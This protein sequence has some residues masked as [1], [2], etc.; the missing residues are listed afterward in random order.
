[1]C[2]A[3]KDFKF[4]TCEEES[5]SDLPHFWKLHRF[6]KDKNLHIIGN[7]I[8]LDNY[9]NPYY[10]PNEKTFLKRLNKN[11]AFDKDILFKEDD[12]LVIVLNNKNREKSMTFCFKYNKGKWKK[13]FCDWLGLESYFDVHEFGVI[14][15][16]VKQ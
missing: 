4:C 11:D 5:T 10:G 14:Q 8:M 7:I 16:L 9:I 1:M 2:I 3:S 6:N 15:N 13:T 12:K